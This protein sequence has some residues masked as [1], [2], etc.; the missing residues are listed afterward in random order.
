MRRAIAQHAQ[1]FVMLEARDP[2]LATSVHDTHTYAPEDIRFGTWH[3]VRYD[4]R[5]RLTV[6]GRTKIGGTGAGYGRTAG[7][8]LD[9]PGSETRIVIIAVR[10]R[11]RDRGYKAAIVRRFR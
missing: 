8:R 3:G 11:V 4:G 7:T 1:V 2:T 6:A 10:Y 5:G 9:R